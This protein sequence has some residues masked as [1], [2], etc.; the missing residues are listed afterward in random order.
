MQ[1]NRE[2]DYIFDI[3]KF[4]EVIGKT[5]PYILYSYLRMNK[6]L[7]TY[8]IN[9]YLSEEI[10]NDYDRNLRLQILDLENNLQNA[11]KYRMPSYIAN[12]LYDLCV[13]LNAF[14]QFNHI[15]NLEDVKKQQDWLY[16]LNLS[17]NIIKDMLELLGIYIPSEM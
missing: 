11:Y 2:K 1:N 5:G 10:Y 17:N 15:N 14:Y 3:N 13:L 4:S 8:T 9:D 16:L 12:Y 6:I 7:K